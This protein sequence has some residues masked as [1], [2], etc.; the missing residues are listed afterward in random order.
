MQGNVIVVVPFLFMVLLYL[1]SPENMI[2]VFRSALGRNIL[3][4]A[5]IF[6]ATGAML[7]RKILKQEIL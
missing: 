6:Q 4:T 3:I 7:V 5:I 2:P 1:V